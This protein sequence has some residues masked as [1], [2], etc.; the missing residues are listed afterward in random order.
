MHGRCLRRGRDRAGA[1]PRRVA[2]P[3]AAAGWIFVKSAAAALGAVGAVA[4]VATLTGVVSWPA[5]ASAPE[6]PAPVQV[7]PPRAV[8]PR[9]SP[10]PVAPASA[11]EPEVAAAKPNPPPAV[12]APS[13]S[14]TLSA[15]STLLEQARREVRRDPAL[16]LSIAGEHAQR[17]P[18]G[19]LTSE[20]T[21]IQV[22]ALHRLGRYAEARSLGRGLLSG[23]S[24]DLYRERARKLLAGSGPRDP[25]GGEAAP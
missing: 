6:P 11:S 13:S 20:R 12:A 18:R 22:E 5:S 8:S 25:R 2:L 4:T 7:A 24:A 17:F 23:A 9:V 14:G 15:E 19:Q 1:A 21:L 3:V 16:S 10:L